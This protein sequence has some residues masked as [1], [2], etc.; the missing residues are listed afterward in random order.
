M[1][2]REARTPRTDIRSPAPGLAPELLRGDQ[3]A[4]PKLPRRSGRP[5]WLGLPAQAEDQTKE[6]TLRLEL[7]ASGRPS[8]IKRSTIGNTFRPAGPVQHHCVHLRAPQGQT[9]PR[10]G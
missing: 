1:P 10:R 7:V 4:D 2:N 9:R 6:I 3:P 5:P 8:Q